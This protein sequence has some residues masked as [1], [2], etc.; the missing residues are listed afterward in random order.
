MRGTQP[1]PGAPRRRVAVLVTALA[2]MA[3]AAAVVV[4][5][6]ITSTAEFFSRYHTLERRYVNLG[7]SAHEGIGCRTCHE[8]DA[9]A[10]G[11][12][13]LG[14]FY[15]SLVETTATPRFF[16]FTSPEN[17]AC[18]ACH[19]HDWSHDASRTATIPHPAHQRVSAETRQ[20]TDCH[21]WTAHFETYM[22]KHKQMPFSGVCV[23]YGCHVGT[24]AADECFDCHHVLHE[25]N[26]TWRTDHPAVIE[27]TGPNAC[28]EGCH[29]IEQC[30]QCH[31]TG[32]RPEFDGLPIETGMR[33]IEDLHVR[34]EWTERYHGA[35]AVKNRGNCLKCHQSEG[36]CDEC[37]LERP[38]SHGP[39]TA[40][41]GRHSKTTQDLND[42]RCLE[43]HEQPWCD[44]CH[45]QF[46]EM[47]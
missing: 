32:T 41:I 8:T 34:A 46:K 13:L 27:R 20:C 40:W 45:Q 5:L 28:V 36:E 33:A 29:T 12:A 17:D 18:L 19:E 11:A 9:V 14:D 26:E 1:E 35:E 25:A 22:V 2:V 42:P 6:A 39:T 30:Q 7:N 44:D 4:P 24:K 15:T 3:V 10:N 47:E 31:T 23:S 21:K 16:T 38:E 43:C 37:H